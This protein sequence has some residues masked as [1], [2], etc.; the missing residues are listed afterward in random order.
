MRGGSPSGPPYRV[1]EFSLWTQG[2]FFA[3]IMLAFAEIFHMTA[4]GWSA[5]GGAL[6]VLIPLKGNAPGL[7]QFVQK[8]L[9][10]HDPVDDGGIPVSG[11]EARKHRLGLYFLAARED[12]DAAEALA[13]TPSG[14]R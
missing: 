6:G 4:T 3:L 8:S 10:I 7:M 11:V 2:P 5:V 1:L 12:H 9:F 13:S 14:P